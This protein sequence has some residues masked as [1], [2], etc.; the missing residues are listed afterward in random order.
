MY[1]I[2]TGIYIHT[3]YI[4][5]YGHVKCIYLILINIY[6]YKLNI[7]NSMLDRS[8]YKKMC[9][10]CE[11][12]QVLYSVVP[13]KF[14]MYSCWLVNLEIKCIFMGKK[15]LFVSTPVKL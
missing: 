4:Y 10:I 11:R 8:L 2:Y 5:I 3:S 13:S 1:I 12:N 9:D 14:D 7:N 15:L 6:I